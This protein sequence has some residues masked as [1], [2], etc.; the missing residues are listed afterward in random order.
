MSYRHKQRVIRPPET[1]IVF[2]KLSGSVPL[3]GNV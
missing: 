2:A 1:F 3:L